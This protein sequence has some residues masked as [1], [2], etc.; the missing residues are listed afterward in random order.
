MSSK[1]DEAPKT[2]NAAKGSSA[3]AQAVTSMMGCF[4]P[5][6]NP[7][8]TAMDKFFGIAILKNRMGPL[9]TCY[10]DWDG[11]TGRITQMEDI[12]RQ[13]LQQ[14]LDW[15]AQNSSKDGDGGL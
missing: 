15:K 10:F 4:R 7:E 14:F 5:G 12:Q 13:E 11:P 6:Y 8:D 1:P 9:G 2:Y 3:I